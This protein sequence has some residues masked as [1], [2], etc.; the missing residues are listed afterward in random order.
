MQTPW[1]I[2]DESGAASSTAS[3]EGASFRRIS[4]NFE[5]IRRLRQASPLQEH[6]LTPYGTD[7]DLPPAQRSLPD[8]QVEM[9]G[10]TSVMTSGKNSPPP[11]RRQIS[12]GYS[13]R[14]EEVLGEKRHYLQD[15][16]PP[17]SI[18]APPRVVGDLRIQAA[19]AMAA[20]GSDTIAPID[21]FEKKHFAV[22]GDAWSPRADKNQFATSRGIP[23]G[24]QTGVT[25]SLEV[26][27]ASQAA[28]IRQQ[29]ASSSAAGR[30]LEDSLQDFQSQ[31]SRMRSAFQSTR[32]PPVS[33]LAL[34]GAAAGG[35]GLGGPA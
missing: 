13:P 8:R 28:Q 15:R 24:S 18:T 34:G 17:G 3:A 30:A 4:P 23:A 32:Q 14:S 25:R 29:L 16:T 11:T 1:A 20:A 6:R 35:G 19:A 12:D 7:T 9:T 31:E 26:P 27:P 10:V 21:G 2:D 5:R 22:V 33:P